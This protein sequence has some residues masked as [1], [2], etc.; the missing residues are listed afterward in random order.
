MRLPVLM[1]PRRFGQVDHHV[2]QEHAGHGGQVEDE[3]DGANAG[4]VINLFYRSLGEDVDDDDQI[5]GDDEDTVAT[6]EGFEQILNIV[7]ISLI[8]IT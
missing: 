8:T 1:R 7:L 4:V 6:G 5:D 2:D 3:A